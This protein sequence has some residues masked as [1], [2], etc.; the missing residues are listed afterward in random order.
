MGALIVDI[1]ATSTLTSSF[2]NCTDLQEKVI[3]IQTAHGE[4]VMRTT[5]IS[6]ITFFMRDRLGRPSP[7]TTRAHITPGLKHD[8]LSGRA[9]NRAGYRV[10]LVSYHE[11]AGI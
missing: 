1:G 5:H 4:T 6:W 8:L 9:L 3:V 7:I 2:E 10:I 11:E